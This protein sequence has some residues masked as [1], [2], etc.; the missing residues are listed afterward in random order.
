MKI[1][2][3]RILF[4]SKTKHKNLDNGFDIKQHLLNAIN[5]IKF[6]K[7]HKPQVSS[8]QDHS[9]FE[10]NTFRYKGSIQIIRVDNCQQHVQDAL[11]F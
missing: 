4:L 1:S 5:G 3:Y 6:Y 8:Y 2:Y 10:M 11:L 7:T 9:I